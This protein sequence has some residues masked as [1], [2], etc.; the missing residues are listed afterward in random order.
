MKYLSEAVSALTIALFIPMLVAA[1][2]SFTFDCNIKVCFWLCFI[3][4]VIVVIGVVNDGQIQSTR[5]ETDDD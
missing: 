4:N 5:E 3:L 2:V 1:I